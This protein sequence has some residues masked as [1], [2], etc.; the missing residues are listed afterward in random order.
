MYRTMR[1]VIRSLRQGKIDPVELYE[2]SVERMKRLEHLN[3]IITATTETA[4]QQ[5]Q[6]SSKR[7]RASTAA[8]SGVILIHL[9]DISITSLF[10]KPRDLVAIL[11]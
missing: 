6:H 10:A 9:L 8:T 1:Q 5:A 3:A 4:Q 2:Q 11:I 7:F